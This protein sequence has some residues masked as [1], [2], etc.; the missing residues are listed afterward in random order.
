MLLCSFNPTPSPAFPGQSIFQIPLYPIPATSFP[1]LPSWLITTAYAVLSRWQ[2]ALCSLAA[3]LCASVGSAAVCVR[4]HTAPSSTLVQFGCSDAT[5]WLF[6]RENAM[7]GCVAGRAARLCI[8]YLSEEPGVRREL[9]IA[10]ADT[11]TCAKQQEPALA[12]VIAD[13]MA[14]S[15]LQPCSGGQHETSCPPLPAAGRIRRAQLGTVCP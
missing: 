14:M 9:E 12:W 6:A 5:P 15:H 10:L 11:D 2:W 13:C 8:P 3:F 1:A 7:P 4:P